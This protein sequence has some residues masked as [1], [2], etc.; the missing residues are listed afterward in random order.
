MTRINFYIIE[1]GS[2]EATQLFIC[3]LTEK[4]WNQDNAIYIHTEN[5]PAAHQLDDDLWSFNETSFIPHQLATG[6]GMD[7]TVLIGHEQMNA[8]IPNS[9]HD[10]MINLGHEIPSFF[11]Q[12][13]RLAEIITTDEISKEKGRDRYRFYKDRGYAL[14]TH[15]LSL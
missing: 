2:A 15:K 4:A 14:E 10:V 9:H 3:R 8:V 13:E 11:S 12:F 7:K 5:E 6:A 1:E